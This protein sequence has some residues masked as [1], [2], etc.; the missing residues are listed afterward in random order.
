LEPFAFEKDQIEQVEG[1]ALAQEGRSNTLRVPDPGSFVPGC[2]KPRR[3][4]G[5]ARRTIMLPP[6]AITI[7]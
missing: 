1:I 4:P 7:K 2:P 3:S 5:A 6:D